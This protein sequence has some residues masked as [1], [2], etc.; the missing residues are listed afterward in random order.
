VDVDQSLMQTGD[1]L[2][3]RRISGDSASWMLLEGGVANHA[4][5]IVTD[6]DHAY[7]KYVIDIPAVGEQNLL[8]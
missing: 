5:M 7:T 4:A 2:I 8:K 6:P 1:I 3:G